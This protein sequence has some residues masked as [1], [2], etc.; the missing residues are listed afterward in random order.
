MTI[1]LNMKGPEGRETVDELS[2]AD[3]PDRR[4]FIKE[5]NRLISEYSLCG[6]NVY[7]SSRMCANWKE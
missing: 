5:A 1:Y 2:R 4:S 6:M 7:K 3:F